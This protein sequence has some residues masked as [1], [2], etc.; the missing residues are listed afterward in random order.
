MKKY[1]GAHNNEISMHN[2]QEFQR[3]GIDPVTGFDLDITTGRPIDPDL[4]LLVDPVT[5]QTVDPDPNLP[6]VNPQ[7]MPRPSGMMNLKRNIPSPAIIDDNTTVAALSVVT[8]VPTPTTASGLILNISQSMTQTTTTRP[9][10][11]QAS[12][13]AQPSTSAQ[14]TT[15]ATTVTPIALG[16]NSILAPFELLRNT[17]MDAAAQANAVVLN[18]QRQEEII[19][20][21]RTEIVVLQNQVHQEQ[22]FHVQYVRQSNDARSNMEVTIER[23]RKAHQEY[24]KS[25]T[26]A[27]KAMESENNRTVTALSEIQE[28][29]IHAK[30]LQEKCKTQSKELIGLRQRV[31]DLEKQAKKSAKKNVD[32]MKRLHAYETGQNEND[33]CRKRRKNFL[34]NDRHTSISWQI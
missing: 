2:T 11:P 4:N 1:N 23:E 7:P 18:H 10:S 3:F 14:I 20:E 34:R 32:L 15:P 9:T 17:F 27:R 29:L 28:E 33:R 8:T 22:A 5:F 21:L 24:V 25:T 13:L 26:E 30:S 19:A 31:N 12:T 16:S 6:V